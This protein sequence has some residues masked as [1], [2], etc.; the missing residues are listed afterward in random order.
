MSTLQDTKTKQSTLFINKCNIDMNSIEYLA[1][2]GKQ[3]VN[4]I[5]DDNMTT[6][7]YD[8]NVSMSLL[9]KVIKY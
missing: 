1:G 7:M 4:L 2:I 6:D 8:G 3:F 9:I 5:Q